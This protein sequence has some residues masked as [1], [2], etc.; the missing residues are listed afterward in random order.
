MS[1]HV[2]QTAHGRMDGLEYQRIMG[3]TR[4]DWTMKVLVGWTEVAG[5]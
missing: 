5:T 4:M 2:P 1:L 3:E